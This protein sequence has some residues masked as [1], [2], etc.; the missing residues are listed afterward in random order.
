MMYKTKVQGIKLK[1]VFKNGVWKLLIT[2]LDGIEDCYETASTPN[3]IANN[4]AAHAPTGCDDYDDLD[5]PT[6]P[7][8]LSEWK[9]SL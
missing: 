6:L 4:V 9:K 8:D 1:I 5:D 3:M 2:D 7:Q